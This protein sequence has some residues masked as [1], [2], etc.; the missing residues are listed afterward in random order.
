M[1]VQDGGAIVAQDGGTRWWSNGGARWRLKMAAQD[2]GLRWQCNWQ[3]KELVTQN[4]GT[5]KDTRWECTRH[6][7]QQAL[8]L[9][10]LVNKSFLVYR[11]KASRFDTA[12]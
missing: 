10:D 1:W 2:G 4:G 6:K 7:S 5:S 11:R 12:T 9:P 8:S 3:V